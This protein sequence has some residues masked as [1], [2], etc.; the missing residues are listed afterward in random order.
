MLCLYFWFRSSIWSNWLEDCVSSRSKVSVVRQ[1]LSGHTLNTSTLVQYISYSI[2][3]QDIIYNICIIQYIYNQCQEIHFNSSTLQYISYSI[4]LTTNALVQCQDIH[5]TLVP[6]YNN[7]SY[8][9]TI[10]Q[11]SAHTFESKT[12]V[13]YTS[14]KSTTDARKYSKTSYSKTSCTNTSITSITGI[15]STTNAGTYIIQFVPIEEQQAKCARLPFICSYSLGLRGHW[16]WFHF[17]FM[18]GPKQT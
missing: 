6:F 4:K 14:I 13:Q 2:Q 17:G 10:V 3:C 11:Y 12:P 16:Y 9:R 15:Q 1:G 8:S 7:I 18:L 5:F